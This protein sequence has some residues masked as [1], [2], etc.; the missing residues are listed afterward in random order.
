MQ[1]FLPA[2]FLVYFNQFQDAIGEL[3]KH[4][5]IDENTKFHDQQGVTFSLLLKVI[6]NQP[7]VSIAHP[8][9]FLDLGSIS[10]LLFD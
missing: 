8:A 3:N 10:N 5:A 1:P 7:L 9:L 4:G 2:K 6:S